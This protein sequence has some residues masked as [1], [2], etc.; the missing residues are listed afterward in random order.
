MPELPDRPTRDP[1]IPIK[2]P[3]VPMDPELWDAIKKLG[4]L[5][6]IDD[7]VNLLI[8]LTADGYSRMKKNPARL[9]QLY[10][11]LDRLN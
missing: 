2:P 3:M 8:F 7:T 10:Y 9:R 4:E 11:Q 5:A 1:R 6:G